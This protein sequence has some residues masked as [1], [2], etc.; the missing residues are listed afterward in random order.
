MDNNDAISE[1]ALFGTDFYMNKTAG[2]NSDYYG[3]MIQYIGNNKFK[4]IARINPHKFFKRD[5]RSNTIS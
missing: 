3:R 1:S 5:E 4:Q 2:K